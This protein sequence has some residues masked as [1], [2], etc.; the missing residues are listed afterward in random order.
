MCSSP[1]LCSDQLIVEMLLSPIKSLT[2]HSVFHYILPMHFFLTLSLLVIWNFIF[3][4]F[5]D[6]EDLGFD[7]NPTIHIESQFL[8]QY[9]PPTDWL[10]AF[11]I[12][13]LAACRFHGKYK[14]FDLISLILRNIFHVGSKNDLH[15]S[16]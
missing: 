9:L 2:L 3:S 7:M 1:F 5:K 10:H 4:V 8:T 14:R 12:F 16:L 13:Q 6:F 11:S 15:Q